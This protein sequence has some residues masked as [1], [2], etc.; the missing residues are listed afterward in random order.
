MD[1]EYLEQLRAD[2]AETRADLEQRELELEDDSIKAHDLLMERLR[3][4]LIEKS[5][6][7]AIVRKVHDDARVMPQ[8]QLDDAVDGDALAP[9][10]MALADA[11]FQI[12]QE[13]QSMIDNAVASLRER[14]ATLEGQLNMLMSMIGNGNSSNKEFEASE[15]VR[16]LRVR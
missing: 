12:R 1:E 4:S 5:A 15:V 11:I 10:Q 13:T 2:A 6:M 7:P 3:S 8:R 14:I 9:D 16:K